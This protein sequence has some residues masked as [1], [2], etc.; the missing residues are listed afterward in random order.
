MTFTYERPL[1]IQSGPQDLK[2]VK[3]THG[4]TTIEL[5]DGRIL[6]VSLHIDSVTG[7]GDQV[8]VA[9]SAISEVMPA[10]AV[11]IADVHETLQ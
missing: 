7:E 9:Y 6:R 2:V 8:N 4:V 3:V 5:S 1:V 11:P 10:P